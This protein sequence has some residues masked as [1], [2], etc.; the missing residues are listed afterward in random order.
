VINIFK[1]DSSGLHF[2]KE[3]WE[4]DLLLRDARRLVGKD[5]YEVRGRRYELLTPAAIDRAI[6]KYGAKAPIAVLYSEALQARYA[7]KGTR[8]VDGSAQS[9]DMTHGGDGSSGEVEHAAATATERNK[10]H[11]PPSP[12]VGAGEDGEHSPSRRHDGG[13]AERSDG[14]NAAEGTGAVGAESHEDEVTEGGGDPGTDQGPASADDPGREAS[15]A[16]GADDGPDGAP[17]SARTGRGEAASPP[18]TFGGVYAALSLGA[19]VPFEHRQAARDIL[20]ALRRLVAAVVSSAPDQQ[21]PRY[22]G[23]RLVSELVSRRCAVGRARREE[24]GLPLLV[25]SCDVSGSCSSAAP[26]TIAAAQALTAAR[27]DVVVVEHS[28][29]F[30][31]AVTVNGARRDADRLPRTLSWWETLVP[32]DSILLAF[33]DWDAGDIY[34]ALAQRGRTVIWLDS[35]AAR[36]AGVR[37]VK[38]GVEIWTPEA[39]ACIKHWYTGVNSPARA[40]IAL[41]EVLRRGGL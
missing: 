20:R 33:G 31:I 27:P 7:P 41:R 13:D 19:T 4:S 14:A 6:S 8:E 25:V 21:S 11:Q 5:G 26:G 30:P 28:N 40:A 37:R 3:I 35:Y 23:R 17:R 10:E 15:D 38:K 24:L 29:G 16:A 32:A 39:G 34:V 22:D 9:G 36:A 12:S 2:Q 1:R 18:V